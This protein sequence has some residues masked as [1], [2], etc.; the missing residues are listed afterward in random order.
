VHVDGVGKLGL[1]LFER[2]KLYGL[3][4]FQAAGS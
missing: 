3:S 4:R 1:S 2:A